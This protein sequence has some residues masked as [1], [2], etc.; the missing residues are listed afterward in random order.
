MADGFINNTAKNRFELH[1][2]GAFAYADYRVN[3]Q[4]LFIDKVEAPVA[5][6]GTGVA[7]RLMQNI[8][9]AA[10]RAGLEIVPV[11]PYAVS[12]L[13]RQQQKPPA[14]PKP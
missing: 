13:Q 4:Q 7:G 1:V 3:G 12:W 5:L 8:V 14:A 2:G 9:D 11:C 6:R 10:K